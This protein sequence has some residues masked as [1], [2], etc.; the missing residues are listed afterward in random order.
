MQVV[1]CGTFFD[2]FGSLDGEQKVFFSCGFVFV[3]LGLAVTSMVTQSVEEGAVET[4]VKAEANPPDI[5]TD[6]QAL[7]PEAM[8]AIITSGRL[9]RNSGSISSADLLLLA[10]IQKSALCFGGRLVLGD[11]GEKSLSSFG[12]RHASEDLFRPFLSRTPSFHES[13]KGLHR[14]ASAPPQMENHPL[15]AQFGVVSAARM[16]GAWR[17]CVKT[18]GTSWRPA[19]PGASGNRWSRC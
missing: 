18:L 17:C 12:R 5:F 4:E 7:R 16:R 14:A 13:A 8:A 15:M 2:E 9:Q 6:S 11:S 1:V 3:M 19:P 10:E